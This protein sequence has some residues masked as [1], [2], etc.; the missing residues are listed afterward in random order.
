MVVILKNLTILSLLHSVLGVGNLGKEIIPESR[1]FHSSVVIN[2]YMIIY[3]G[4][5]GSKKDNPSTAT[6]SS[7]LIVYDIKN[8]KW[9]QPKAT[10]PAPAMKFHSA[11]AAS[12]NKMYVYSSAA[13]GSAIYIL[14]TSSWT[15]STFQN[16]NTEHNKPSIGA[17]INFAKYQSQKTQKIEEQ[18]IV[19]GGLTTNSDGSPGSASAVTQSYDYYDINSQ[20]SPASTAG[21]QISH[22]ASCAIVDSSILVSFGGKDGSGIITKTTQFLV[23]NVPQFYPGGNVENNPTDRICATLTCIGNKAILLGGSTLDWKSV[24]DSSSGYVLSVTMASGAISSAKWEALQNNPDKAP[25]LRIGQSA[26]AYGNSIIVYGGITDNS[27]ESDGSTVYILDTNSYKWDKSLPKPSSSGGSTD[28]SSDGTDN[29]G[30]DKSSGTSTTVIIV[31][32]LVPIL[33][34][35]GIGTCLFFGL[36][37]WRKKKD[38]NRQVIPNSFSSPDEE[39]KHMSAIPPGFPPSTASSGLPLTHMN[40]SSTLSP[41]YYRSSG[42]HSV[43]SDLSNQFAY[44]STS[45]TMTHSLAINPISPVNHN[46]QMMSRSTNLHQ[47]LRSIP[48]HVDQQSANVDYFSPLEQIAR[49]QHDIS[50]ISQPETPRWPVENNTDLFEQSVAG[51][52]SLRDN[53]S[54]TLD[55][56]HIGPEGFSY[57]MSETTLLSQ[58]RSVVITSPLLSPNT[59]LYNL[60]SRKY[61]IMNYSL[62]MDREFGFHQPISVSGINPDTLLPVTIWIYNSP[63]PFENDMEI[64]QQLEGPYILNLV[65]NFI[66]KPTHNS[67]YYILVQERSNVSLAEALVSLTQPLSDIEVRSICQQIVECL[68]YCHSKSYIV[69]DLKP[70]RF[71]FVCQDNQPIRLVLNSIE[72]CVPFDTELDRPSLPRHCSPE[73]ARTYPLSSS[74]IALASPS[75]DMWALGCLLYELYTCQPLFDPTLS[76]DQLIEFLGQPESPNFTLSNGVQWARGGEGLRWPSNTSLNVEAH[77]ILECLLASQPDSRLSSL[78]LLES[79]FLR[80][81]NQLKHGESQSSLNILGSPALPLQAFECKFGPSLRM[82]VLQLRQQLTST[83]EVHIPRLPVITLGPGAG[84]N[85]ENSSTWNS[86]TFV[87]HFL[88]EHD[89]LLHFTQHKGYPIIHPKKFFRRSGVFLAITS[90]LMSLYLVPEMYDLYN[91]TLPAMQ[92]IQKLYTNEQHVFFDKL[93]ISLIEFCRTDCIPELR[94]SAEEMSHLPNEFEPTSSQPWSLW[95]GMARRVISISRYQGLKSIQ[96]LLGLEWNHQCKEIGQLRYE[97]TR[98]SSIFEVESNSISTRW[99]GWKCEQHTE[100]SSA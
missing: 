94:S 1:A 98:P 86:Q 34:I 80:S 68:D 97:M 54:S 19:Y 74:E 38:Q 47:N 12:N 46:V 56:E 96:E 7:D 11:T 95:V 29:S 75:M 23:Y 50:S 73:L 17:T 83:C 30:S 43:D 91:T 59:P 90:K 6:A 10:N 13:N 51:R 8:K 89:D 66:L 71:S 18:L 9:Y 87:L 26:A 40:Q 65:D 20:T 36:K 39:H 70:S 77:E 14:D 64:I 81:L 49:L 4:I 5:I 22:H 78:E 67:T 58:R 3:G 41:S 57:P 44:E 79:E 82:N 100:P 76:P 93:S 85:W 33:V 88:C 35:A 99:R 55:S 2:D 37:R 16:G 61:T 62:P 84:N 25:S 53:L 24:S 63:I 31:S 45:P 72:G 32:V 15:W 92:T 48:T 60:L 28:S 27:S 21:S 42:H 69:G 52:R